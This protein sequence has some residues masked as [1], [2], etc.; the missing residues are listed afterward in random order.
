[1]N[2]AN[3]LLDV[4]GVSRRFGGLQAL[5]DVSFDV[6]RGEILALIGPNGAGKST[7]LGVVSGS[8]AADTGTV[9]FKGERIDGL[10]AEQVNRRGLVRTFQ[11]AEVLRQMTVLENVMAAGVAHAQSGIL[12]GL[13]GFGRAAEVGR[14]LRSTGMEKLQ[15]VALE[16][17]ANT[18]AALLTAG[19]QRL[20]SIARAL[21][22]GAELL[23]LDEPAAGLNTLEKR[24]LADV[25]SRIRA[26]GTTVVF[27]EHDLA[28]V[29]RL[30][31]RMVV[32]NHGR[33]IAKGAP[34]DVRKDPAVVE[35]YLGN[36]DLSGARAA[37]GPVWVRPVVLAVDGLRLRYGG[38]TALDGVD[39][40]VREGEIVAL[41]G[42]NGAGKS[43]LLNAIAGTETPDGG[44][45]RFEGKDLAPLKKE[46][47]TGA[48]ISLAPE[49]RALFP[50]LT[51]HDNLLMG[52]YARMRLSG[53]T[54]LLW[55]RGTARGE[56]DAVMEEVLDFFPRLRE[57]LHQQAGTLSGGEQ[58]MLAIGR[59]L[60][61]RPKLLMLDE[62]SFG[63]APQVSRE[64]L[65]SLVRLAARG[66]TVLLVE[67][68]ARSALQ[69]A[70]RAYILVNG[71]I[72][73]NGA[74]QELLNRPDITQAYL[75]WESEPAGAE[76][77]TPMKVAA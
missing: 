11:G 64:I 18:N 6:R 38:L 39:L 1:M 15:V 14:Q 62:P 70:D 30:A 33:V 43:T 53:L 73:A 55:P 65:E 5:G 49:G 8:I 31:E 42:A 34:E 45:L 58:Q 72:V 48:G 26:K 2:N 66:M 67:Q 63:L 25:I 27:V 77:D 23:I 40:E 74:S 20:L 69:V 41:I 24:V 22:T 9:S 7:L 54:Q 59:A 37:T 51:V 60:M 35:A 76:D 57:R 16:R 47:R 68:N 29:S 19:Q 61:N 52:R 46:Q 17:L 50:A 75:G 36:T 4:Q 28:F 3:I 21:A 10:A 44:T 56:M 32:L 13:L 71:R 12:S